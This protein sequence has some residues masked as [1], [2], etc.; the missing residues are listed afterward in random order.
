M[1]DKVLKLSADIERKP[2]PKYYDEST[3]FK[4]FVEFR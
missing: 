3:K 4:Y 1:L 2:H